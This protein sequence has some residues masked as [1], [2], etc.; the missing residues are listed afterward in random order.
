MIRPVI[1]GLS[2]ALL[3]G[4]EP[5]FAED[6]PSSPRFELP[7][8]TL[9]QPMPS[10]LSSLPLAQEREISIDAHHERSLPRPEVGQEEPPPADL[11]SSQEQREV[12]FEAAI[13]AAIAKIVNDTPASTQP[14]EQI[15]SSER[16]TIGATVSA[17]WNVGSMSPDARAT[18]VTVAFDLNSDGSL[19]P[20]SIK[21]LASRGGDDLAAQEAFEAARR[22]ILRCGTQ[23]FNLPQEKFDQWAHIELEFAPNR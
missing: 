10:P 11:A 2:V 17:C 13:A 15:T 8:P 19:V 9:F 16:Q 20:D 6:T 4:A 12:L 3:F 5:L 22:A 23:G 14:I 7:Q 18:A 1:A 21:F